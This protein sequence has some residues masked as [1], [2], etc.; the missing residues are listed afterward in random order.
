[1]IITRLDMT[2][3]LIVTSGRFGTPWPNTLENKVFFL[4]WA[5]SEHG[6]TMGARF[7]MLDTEEG[8]MPGET[9]F[10]PAGVKDYPSLQEG[11]EATLRVIHN[12]L[13]DRILSALQAGNTATAA[14]SLPT[15][16]VWGTGTFPGN[17]SLAR[18]TFDLLSAVPVGFMTTVIDLPSGVDIMGVTI[19]TGLIAVDGVSGGHKLLF[20]VPVADRATA[21]DWS[22]MDLSDAARLQ[23][24]T[25]VTNF[26]S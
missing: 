15:L 13:Y 1:M 12:G 16:R 10:N 9:T 3:A 11:V 20:T 4:A 17:I 18:T 24:V 19:N 25:G 8:G 23:G 7:N 22:I 5:Y 2:N 6:L 26:T 21:R 14:A